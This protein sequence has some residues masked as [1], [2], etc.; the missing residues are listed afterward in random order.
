MTCVDAAFKREQKQ[1]CA[2]G[3]SSVTEGG[4]SWIWE[5]D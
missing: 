4:G 1:R 3:M 2:G 5:S